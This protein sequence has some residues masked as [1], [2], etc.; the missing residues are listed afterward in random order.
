MQRSIPVVLLMLCA[1]STLWIHGGEGDTPLPLEVSGRYPSLTM[2]NH[3]GECGTG[4]VA[5][6]ADR[7]WVITYGPHME[8]G[9]DD[10]LYEIDA[11]LNRVTHPESVGGTPADRLIHKESNQLVIGP[12]FI[13]DKRTVRAVSPKIMPG[14]L[15]A[16]L[17]SLTDPQNKVLIQTMEGVLW[18][19]DAKTLE[20]KILFDRPVP[21]WHSKGGY[22]GQG[23]IVVSNNG[24]LPAH[25]KKNE[26]RA[27]ADA[28]DPEDAGV[29]A[30]FDGKTWH[31]VER[32]QFTDVTSAGGINGAP[33]NDA[34]LWSIGWDKRSIMLKVLDAGAWHTYRL[35]KADFSYDGKHGW[36]TEWPRIREV[37]GGKFLMN[38][39]G[40]WF[41]FPKTMSAAN[42]GGLKPIGTY[43]KI[44]GD[45]CAWNDTI[46]FGCD[47][48]AKSDFRNTGS[49]PLSLQSQSNLWFT[50]WENLAHNGR[51]AGWGGPWQNDAV[52][53]GAPSVPFL[54]GGY[55]QRVLHLAN[56][57]A[58]AINVNIEID[59]DGTGKWS[60]YKSIPVP[61]N[62]YAF[63]IFPND[64]PGQWVRVTA[65]KDCANATAYFQ[66][67][68]GGGVETQRE[69]FASLAEITSPDAWTGGFAHALGDDKG[70]LSFE[71]Q[72]VEG[73]KAAPAG[74]FE[75]SPD[76][77][78]KK[79]E[80]SAA[81]KF[82][83]PPQQLKVEFDDASVI[84]T[85]DPKDG[86]KRFRLP[87]TDAAYDQPSA[88]P[89]RAVREVVTER[90]LVNAHGS[91]YVL[92]RPNSGGAER[93]KPVCTHLK[94]INDIGS[95]RGLLAISGTRV[96]AKPDAHFHASADGKAGLFFCDI[97][98]L[99]KLGKPVGTGGPWKNSAVKASVPSD[100]YLMTGY[101][102]KTIA[103]SHDAQKEVAFTIEVN[104]DC[105]GWHTYQTLKVPAGQSV[106]H[107]FPSGYS[108]H[109]LRVIVDSDCKA[110]AQC[111]YE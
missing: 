79:V 27:G 58:Q 6:W 38:M 3:N 15:T 62:G 110:T 59:A 85:E 94:R 90:S 99:W 97:D 43:L 7:L 31:I 83:L 91:L 36:H 37:T 51:A 21:G 47:D 92:P 54:F 107:E 39:H 81:N 17:R 19:V 111:K 16:A 89:E 35:P 26:Y 102:K 63:H 98:D 104:I 42:Y 18:E 80:D 10:K 55:A 67:G 20:P 66:Y 12:Y 9:S 74:I 96:D 11:K 49:N 45:F 25:K 34:P 28:K 70:T 75:V 1:M 78:F 86:G 56:G 13:D 69:L 41:E 100:P 23:H 2:F 32:H 5:V 44:T 40:G 53:A 57:D 4:A 61:A 101:D 109:W 52:K 76:L 84:I 82:P 22:S 14:R 105:N 50:K 71:A 29:L 103:L 95:W 77:S 73:G 65:D 68:P 46:V 108:A 64:T 93:I 30:D 8:H 60:A 88:I 87:K 24:E 33:S 48:L 72:M 106:T